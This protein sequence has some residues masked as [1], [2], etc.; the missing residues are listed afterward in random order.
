MTLVEVLVAML[1]MALL[2]A[3]SY[4]ALD[5][6]LRSERHMQDDA[7]A[8]RQPI[9]FFSRLEADLLGYG[10]RPPRRGSV[11]PAPW[12]GD[13]QATAW[14]RQPMGTGETWLRV[15][16]RWRQGRIERLT[17]NEDQPLPLEQRQGDTVL[18][19]VESLKLR[20]LDR[21]GHWLEHWP[22]TDAP[23]ALEVRLRLQGQGELR[24]VFALI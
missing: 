16:Y 9:R 8:L 15:E 1:I 12:L 14:T 22:A 18:E 21:E 13:P 20:Y 2:A 10:Q 6:L 11:A 5:T 17:Q 7:S 24:R 3:L 4:R 19:Q 23:R